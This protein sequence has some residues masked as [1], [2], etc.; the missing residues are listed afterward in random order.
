MRDEFGIQ[1]SKKHQIE[2]SLEIFL[3]QHEFMR[4]DTPILE[5][6]EVF[7]DY[8][9]RQQ[10][11]YRLL[12]NNEVVVLRPDLTL[13]I[14][15][16]LA[17]NNFSLP[18]K[19]YYIG[20]RFKIA[21]SLSGKYN[22]MTQAGVELVGYPSLKAELE[23]FMIINCLSRKFLQGKVRIELGNARF[24]DAILNSLTDDTQLK[25]E[26][27][28]QLYKK[29]IPKYQQLISLFALNDQTD[30]LK[31]WPRL[32]GS[33]ST[34]LRK[35]SSFK[36]PVKAQQIITEL[37]QVSQWV[38][39]L[40]EQSVLLDLSVAP[41]QSYYTGITFKGFSDDIS[42][43]LFSGGRYDH[44]LENFQKKGEPAVGMGIDLE[45]LTKT[46]ELNVSVSKADIL[47]FEPE[48]LNEVVKI[49]QKITNL[50]LCLEDNLQDAKKSAATRNVKLFCIDKKGELKI[51]N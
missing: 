19:L 8:D 25:Q 2:Q 18:R 1:V 4:I 39:K 12:D 7:A 33:A 46:A 32:F 22:Q 14:A 15:R 21:K 50:T 49:C 20:E 48:Q 45:L 11:A 34:V 38:Q 17:T 13:P 41:P 3:Q 37:T 27:K 28:N 51:V 47:F 36:L 35:I 5:Y 43:Y 6:Q 9:L 31:E 10:R 23:C 16:F 42:D 30:F 26:I 40:P 29:N 44:L 24:A